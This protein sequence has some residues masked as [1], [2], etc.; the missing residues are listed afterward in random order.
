[1]DDVVTARGR[2]ALVGAMALTAIISGGM[3][4]FSLGFGIGFVLGKLAA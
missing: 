2:R 4:G 3:F 1:M